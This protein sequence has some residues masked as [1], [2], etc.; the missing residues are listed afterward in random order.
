MVDKGDSVGLVACSD[1][2][3]EI[4]KEQIEEV[5]NIL[6]DMGYKTVIAPHIYKPEE[7]IAVAAELR[8]A[9]FMDMVRNPEI[10]AIFDVSGG[11]VANEVLE[12]LDYGEI[13]DS[14]KP[15]FAYSDNTVVLNAIF[16]KTGREV[17]LYQIRNIIYEHGER[18][19][20]DFE[21]TLS[22]ETDDLYDFDY[23]FVQGKSM[24]GVLV[25]GNI[26][27]LLKLAG[28]GYMPSFKHRVLLL[29]SYSGK[30]PRIRTY[31]TQLKQM[32]VFEEVNGILLGT[33][34]ELESTG[35][36]KASDILRDICADKSL[37]IAVTDEIGH[38]ADSKAVVIGREIELD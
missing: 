11:D 19:K 36:I 24:K 20:A 34:T 10:K 26:R 6:Y 29:E 4:K 8:A 38:G 13:E 33:F 31:F 15:I 2:I 27:C 28:T 1:G 37:P 23:E 22:G 7:G 5:E 18:Q 21:M 32:G 30:E 14:R 9:E 12:Y 3:N 35:E 17:Y 16:Q 25:G